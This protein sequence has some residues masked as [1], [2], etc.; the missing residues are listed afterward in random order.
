MSFFFQIF[1]QWACEMFSSH[2]LKFPLSLPKKA[3]L[4]GFILRNVKSTPVSSPSIKTVLSTNLFHILLVKRNIMSY[5]PSCWPSN[6]SWLCGFVARQPSRSVCPDLLLTELSSPLKLL[7]TQFFST[8]R[9]CDSSVLF[10]G[11]SYCCIN[12]M[13]TICLIFSTCLSQSP[14]AFHQSFLPQSI[15]KVSRFALLVTRYQNFSSWYLGASNKSKSPYWS[16][17]LSVLQMCILSLMSKSCLGGF[18]LNS[19]LEM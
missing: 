10:Q 6:L 2:C 3:S 18:I 19:A 8:K 15:L 5:S 16:L 7:L 4:P 1:A 17:S 14:S 12:Q 13:V 11:L 9:A